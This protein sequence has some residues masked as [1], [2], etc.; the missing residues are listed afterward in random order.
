[1]LARKGIAYR[2]IDMLPV[3]SRPLLRALRFPENTVP[4][5]RLDGRRIQ[6]SRRISRVL[7]EVRPEPALFPPDAER[8]RRVEEAERWGDEVLQNAARRI[9]LWCV[10]REPSGVRMQLEGGQF[11]FPFPARLG[12][13]TA[14]PVI[15]VDLRIVGGSDE[16]VRR[17]LAELPGML[18]RVDGWIAE[19]LLG[20]DEPNA[21]DFQIAPSLRLLSTIEDLRP[22]IESRPAGELARRLVPTFPNR[23]RAGTLPP[24]LRAPLGAVGPAV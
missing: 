15:W 10:L 16:V 24:D 22:A 21:A 19:G 11:P 6:G 1:M 9:A 12:A 5:L 23:V 4:A 2:R 18:D 17:D 20:A 7:D 13:M 8:R 14:K 3:V